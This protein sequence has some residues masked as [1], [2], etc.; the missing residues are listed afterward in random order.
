[1]G[2]G[3]IKNVHI[4]ITETLINV[5]GNQEQERNVVKIKTVDIGRGDNGNK[6]NDKRT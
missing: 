2:V 5:V 4:I 3:A 1:M 6:K